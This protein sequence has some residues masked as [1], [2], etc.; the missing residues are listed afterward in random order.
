MSRIKTPITGITTTSSYEEGSCYSLVNFRPKN[1]TLYPV[2]TRKVMQE[3]S[4]KYDIVFVHQNNDYK[5]WIGVINDENYSSV[6]WDILSEKPKNIQSHIQ[7]KINSVQQIG[8]T[9]SLITNDNI[10]YLFYQNKDYTF[11]GEIP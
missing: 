11:L 4:L 7:G 6:C 8:N 5:N 3:L 10:Y 9:V 2:A 1:R